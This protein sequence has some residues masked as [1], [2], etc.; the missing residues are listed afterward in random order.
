MFHIEK[1]KLNIKPAIQN[2]VY[3][4]SVCVHVCECLGEWVSA[5]GVYSTDCGVG[6][7]GEK[8]GGRE[9]HCTGMYFKIDLYISIFD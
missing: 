8:G 6:Q 2:V 3:V 9:L 1:Y 4:V 5:G 7:C